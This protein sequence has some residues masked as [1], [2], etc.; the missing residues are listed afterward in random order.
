MP[1]FRARLSLTL[2]TALFF[3]G[4]PLWA[5]TTSLIPQQQAGPLPTNVPPAARPVGGGNGAINTAPQ[6]F[7]KLRIAPGFLLHIAVFNEPQLTQDVRVNDAG[8]VSLSLAGSVH[9]LGLTDSAAQDAIAAAYKRSEMLKDPQ[10]SLSISE[11]VS[12]KVSILGQVAAPGE[13]E[14]IAPAD[15]M[16][17]LNMAG[18]ATSNAGNRITLRHASDHVE[19]VVNYSRSGDTSNLEK[20]IVNPGDT[21]VVN[22]AGIVYVL[23]AVNR[24][25]G[26]VMQPDGS[27]NVIQALS[28][29]LDTNFYA[30]LNKIRI[31]RKT[32]DGL[33][34]IPVDY[35]LL[36][37]G[38]VDPKPLQ[39]D[40]ILYV[41]NSKTKLG[42]AITKQIG[43]QTSNAIIYSEV[44][45]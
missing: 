13:Y 17:V 11:Y 25:G 40:D 9:V 12:P 26:Y 2:G 20:F 4:T 19:Q 7:E 8:D 5:Q 45:H 31:I 6:N 42:L 39:P 1:K 36:V 18:G 37:N 43:L 28:F 32:D 15:L 27:M 10:V 29:A 35:K 24:P 21:I 30:S 16:T 23:G 3:T 33:I 14:L 38:K 22:R 41:P 44:N 34:E